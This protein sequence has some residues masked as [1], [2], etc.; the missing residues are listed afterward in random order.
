MAACW[1]VLRSK[2][3]K[4][5]FLWEQV[6]AHQ[7]EVFYPAIRAKVVNPRA[8]KMRPYFP[9]YLFVRADIRNLAPSFWLWL[10]GSRGLVSFDDAPATVPDALIAAIRRKVEQINAAGADQAARIQPGESVSIQSGPF[11]EYD[12]IFDRC[13]SGSDR[14]RVLL[15]H[16][17]GRLIPVELPAAQVE[18]KKQFA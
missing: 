10:P 3:N 2:P 12:A 5:N 16:L 7:V 18:Q 15:R 17:Q 8:R 6:L 11:A 13:V 14:V 4:E 9:G 1:Y